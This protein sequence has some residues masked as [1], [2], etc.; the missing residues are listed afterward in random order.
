MR[1]ISQQIERVVSGLADLP[2]KLSS[3]PEITALN[4]KQ[5]QLCFTILVTDSDQSHLQEESRLLQL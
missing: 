5:V 2:E 3:P 4:L 1:S